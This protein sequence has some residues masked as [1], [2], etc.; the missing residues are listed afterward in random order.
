MTAWAEVA[1]GPATDDGQPARVL[2]V[3]PVIALFGAFPLWWALGLGGFIA[4]V[5]AVPMALA[6]LLN[7]RTLVPVGTG[8]WCLFLLWVLASGTRLDDA[9]SRLVFTYRY[10]LYV[11]AGI[12]LLYVFNLALQR[13]DRQI[14]VRSLAAMWV[15]VVVGGLAALAV[16]SFA[17]TTVTEQVAPGALLEN[18]WV[19]D[20]AHAAVAEPD[21]QRP[22][23]PFTYTNEWGANFAL[24]TPFALLALLYRRRPTLRWPSLVVL[25][26]APLLLS[27]NRGAW[28]SLA[29]G[30]VY[31]LTLLRGQARVFG[32]IAGGFAMVV[33]AA[34]LQ[35][36]GVSDQVDESL[37]AR[38]SNETRAFIYEQ[39]LDAVVDEPL[40]GYGSPRPSTDSTA[41]PLGTH[42]HLWMT[43]FSHG[44]P[45]AVLYV[46]FLGGM[47]FRT[48]RVRTPPAIAANMVIATSLV[49]LP[50]YGALPMQLFV[51]MAAAAVALAERSAAADA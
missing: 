40:L 31:S 4:P 27:T 49:Q 3:W 15:G 36:T 43:M 10:G 20:I 17:F 38:E 28:I 48:R 29:A 26:M 45:G 37:E 23:A 25:S 9:G 18:E 34:V 16:P 21:S 6:L 42:G 32:L 8:P 47:L 44:I 22:R 39:T 2:P 12:V 33:L 50:F 35:L 19:A 14:V 5:L 30:L 13:P 51:V 24:L 11:A 1:S 41:P 7:R 46:S